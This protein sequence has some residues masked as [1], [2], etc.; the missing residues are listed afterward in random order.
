[1]QSVIVLKG[2]DATPKLARLARTLDRAK[3]W[4]VTAEEHKRRRSDSQNSALWGVAY[5]VLRDETGN[6]PEDMHRYFCGEFY[7][8]VEYEIFGQTRKKPRRTT[9]TDENG[10]RNVIST[11]DFMDFYAFIQQRAAETVGVYVPDPNEVGT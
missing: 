4:R 3:A 10:K 9:T 11:T 1:M 5:K 7:G 2:E 6:D 8:W